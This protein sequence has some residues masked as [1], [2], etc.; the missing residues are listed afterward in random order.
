MNKKRLLS[1]GETVLSRR[2]LVNGAIL[3]ILALIVKGGCSENG[4]ETEKL[5]I[6]EQV[7]T[8]K[9]QTTVVARPDAPESETESQDEQFCLALNVYHE[10]RSDNFSGRLAVADVVLNR[11]E[12]KYYPDNIC[13]VVYQTQTRVNWKG[14][15]VP[16]RGRCQFSWYCDGQSD[17]PHEKLAWMKAEKVAELLL[18]GEWRG[19][20]EGATHY[21]ATYVEPNWTKDRGMV[22]IGRIGAHKFYKWH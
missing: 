2:F 21:H 4:K 1:I 16:A 6:V 20:S 18:D 13:D 8:P 14:N 12:S 9:I 5:K 19:I 11:V 3:V 10:S 7:E 22:E 17:F 15:V